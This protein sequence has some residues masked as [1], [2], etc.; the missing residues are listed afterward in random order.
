M[1]N[2]C[3]MS[4]CRTDD[5]RP[6]VNVSSAGV[7][8]ALSDTL[9]PLEKRWTWSQWPLCLMNRCVTVYVKYNLQRKT[10]FTCHFKQFCLLYLV[11]KQFC[12]H[13][14]NYDNHSNSLNF[15]LKKSNK[16]HGVL[17]SMYLRIWTESLG[18]PPQKLS[19]MD[20]ESTKRKKTF[21]NS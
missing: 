5:I 8:Y 9:S 16:R 10:S 6:V 4:I 2:P 19:V 17:K 20:K 15:K 11:N 12:A 3:W 21:W 14:P 1:N 7:F 18:I 13:R